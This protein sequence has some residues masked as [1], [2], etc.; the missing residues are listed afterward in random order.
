M[1]APNKRAVHRGAIPHI[2]YVTRGWVENFVKSEMIF[3]CLKVW[4][5][6][7]GTRSETRLPRRDQFTSVAKGFADV[8]AHFDSVMM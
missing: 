7:G 5:R 2:A 1:A 8:F 3:G 6:P 4:R